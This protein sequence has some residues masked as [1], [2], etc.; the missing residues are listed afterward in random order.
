MSIKREEGTTM[1]GPDK[2]DEGRSRKPY[3]KPKLKRVELRAE[4]AVLGACKNSA[5]TGPLQSR[6]SVP[7]ACNALAS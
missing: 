2:N 4:E 3:V 6:C 7:A 5:V 1:S